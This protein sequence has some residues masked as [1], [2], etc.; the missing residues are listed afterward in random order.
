MKLDTGGDGLKGKQTPLAIGLIVV[1]LVV[2]GYFVH[3]LFFSGG[4]VS[5]VPPD[6]T[7]AKR[8]VSRYAGALRPCPALNPALSARR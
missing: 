4:G 3:T 7:N 5:V 6:D 1:I 2:V 8:Y